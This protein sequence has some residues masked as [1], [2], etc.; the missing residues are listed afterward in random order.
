MLL[1]APSSF[2]WMVAAWCH[3]F[4]LAVA[5]PLPVSSKVKAVQHLRWEEMS[6][7]QTNNSCVLRKGN[8][9]KTKSQNTKSTCFFLK[10][11]VR[12]ISGW[13]LFCFVFILQTNPLLLLLWQ[14]K[15]CLSVIPLFSFFL[16]SHGVSWLIVTSLFFECDEFAKSYKLSD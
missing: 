14:I 4:S 7:N 16:I 9:K 5:P 3:L 15:N 6:V 2:Y 1:P 11:L 12:V 13:F 10:S 8:N